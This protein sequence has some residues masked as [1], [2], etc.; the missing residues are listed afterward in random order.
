MGAVVALDGG[1]GGGAGAGAP[2]SLGVIE[3]Y[4]YTQGSGRQLGV[5]QATLRTIGGPGGAGGS[6]VQARWRPGDDVTVAR[7]EERACTLLYRAGGGAAG[8]PPSLSPTTTFVL[9]DPDFEQVEV[10][11]ALFPPAAAALLP[12]GAAVTL[13]L[14]PDG[15]PVA[16]EPAAASVEVVIADAPPARSGAAPG[17]KTAVTDT[18][19]AVRVPNHVR[20]GDRVVVDTRDGSFVRRLV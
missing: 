19:A 2:A 17:L 3:K 9:M 18:G 11:A 12:D 13:T 14:G 4:A 8:G 10:A 5:V 7:L 16:A 1:G 6:T 20:A 15:A